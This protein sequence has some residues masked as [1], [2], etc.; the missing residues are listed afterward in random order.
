MSKIG[1]RLKALEKENEHCRQSRR[2][3]DRGSGRRLVTHR[4]AA[5]LRAP[6]TD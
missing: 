2:G 4:I 3:I 6:A 5:V 1:P